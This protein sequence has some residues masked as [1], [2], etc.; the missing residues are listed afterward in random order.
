M[1]N[2]LDSPGFLEQN[3][4]KLVKT[5]VFSKSF[6][7][8]ACPK[9]NASDATRHDLAVLRS[10]VEKLY[11]SFRG[12]HQKD[13]FLRCFPPWFRT[14]YGYRLH[15]TALVRLKIEGP[16]TEKNVINHQFVWYYMFSG[17]TYTSTHIH[18]NK[19]ITVQL[20]FFLSIEKPRTRL[21][22]FFFRGRGVALGS[23]DCPWM[24]LDNGWNFPVTLIY[25]N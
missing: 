13:M 12:F 4:S 16:F 24:I 17:L 2:L 11:P 14:Q 23:R 25:Y 20:D 7:K 3:M 22:F 9:T 5:T 8:K 10:F 21:G 15:I 19:M 6:P 18:P 1:S